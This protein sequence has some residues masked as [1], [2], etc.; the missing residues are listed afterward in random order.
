MSRLAFV[1]S[2]VCLCSV[3][4]KALAGWQGVDWGASEPEAIAKFQL[5]MQPFHGEDPGGLAKQDD[6]T[7]KFTFHYALNSYNF[8]GFILFKDN[9]VS[10]I[11]LDTKE[12]GACA[13]AQNLLTASHGMP[14]QVLSGQVSIPTWLDSKNSNR[15]R[16]IDVDVIHWCTVIID[17][18]PET[19]QT[20]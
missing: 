3:E 19:H 18:L 4:G 7:A 1:L 10:G 11:R 13:S 20:L 6:G 9:V 8:D 5:P 16:L 14:D 17:R 12:S 15:Y 2:L